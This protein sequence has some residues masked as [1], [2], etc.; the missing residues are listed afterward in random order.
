VFERDD[1]VSRSVDDEGGTEHLGDLQ[2]VVE[3][4]ADDE[5]AEDACEGLDDALDAFEGRDEHERAELEARAEVHAW[6]R[7]DGPACV[8]DW[9][10]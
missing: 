10:P 2:E 7:A 9:Y 1:I 3:A 5:F 6:P 4:F 8:S